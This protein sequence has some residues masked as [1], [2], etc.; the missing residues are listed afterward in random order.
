MIKGIDVVFIHSPNSDLG[1]WYFQVFGLSKGYWDQN[2]QELQTSIG[3]RFAI[4][5]TSSFPSDI[6]KQHVII[7]F[8][9]DDIQQAVNKLVE[10][11]VKFYPSREKPSSMLDLLWL[12]LSKIPMETG[13]SCLK[14]NQYKNSRTLGQ[15][16]LKRLVNFIAREISPLSLIFPCMKAVMAF[17]LPVTISL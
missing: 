1:N 15:D 17:N 2:W 3:S 4:D 14:R 13:C 16:I 11:G 8:L 10:K 6:E 12:L 7:S 9:V 5:I